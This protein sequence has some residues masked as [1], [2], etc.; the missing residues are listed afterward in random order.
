MSVHRYL[1]DLSPRDRVAFAADYPFRQVEASYVFANGQSYRLTAFD[2]QDLAAARVAHGGAEVALA[3]MLAPHQARGLFE[4]RF[5]V[6]ASGSNGSPDQLARKYAGT[7][8]VIPTLVG[9]LRDHSAV[10]AAHL[11]GYGSVPATLHHTPGASVRVFVN[12]LTAQQRDRMD[13]TETLGKHY[14]HTELRDLDLALE[15]GERVR[16][17][18]AYVSITG[19]IAH[20]G[21]A[22]RL[23]AIPHPSAVLPDMSQRAVLDYIRSRI[24]PDILFEDFVHAHITDPVLR[25]AREA[26]LLDFCLPT[27]IAGHG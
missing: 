24:E 25:D 6:V 18:T 17:A 11:T 15:N 14:A 3:D 8:D 7:D 27:R 12:Y 10:Y 16:S 9:T 19:V 20:E 2:T 26:R 21:R 4:E 23:S 1:T 22:Q 13:A 5:P